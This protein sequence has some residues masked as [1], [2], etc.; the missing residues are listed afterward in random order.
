MS[1]SI[2][3]VVDR[4]SAFSSVVFLV[5][6]VQYRI[7]RTYFVP[8]ASHF[9]ST[10][11]ARLLPKRQL[12]HLVMSDFPLSAELV[13]FSPTD[14]AFS[15]QS[16][17]SNKRR[18]SIIEDGFACRL[19]G[20]VHHNLESH[21]IRH[22]LSIITMKTTAAFLLL[23]SSAS[24]FVAKPASFRQARHVVHLEDHIADL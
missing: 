16:Y 3:L 10:S 24:A 13:P 23:A 4:V 18:R 11:Y 12:L 8:W 5:E 22:L 20:H 14:E 9:Q 1:D 7:V 15:F 6:P 17:P 2:S 19:V 21:N